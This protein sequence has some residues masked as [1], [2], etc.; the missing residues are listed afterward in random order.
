MKL[1]LR[2]AD[3]ANRYGMFER[4]RHV[5]VA[6]SGGADS[7]CLLRALVD[8]APQWDLRLSVLH[9]NHKLRGQESEEDELFVVELARQLGLPVTVRSANIAALPDNLEQAGRNAR[10]EFFRD[11]LQT[12]DMEHV[13]VGHTRDDQA[14]TVLFR[15]L[16]GSGGAGLAG[17]RPVTAE[18][19]VRPL[20]E[21]SRVEIEHFLRDRGVA[22]REDSSNSSMRFARNRIRRDLLPQLVRDWNPAVVDTLNRTAEWAHGEEEYWAK[23]IGQLAGRLISECDHGIFL[24]RAADLR[25]QPPAVGRR[26]VRHILER[27]KGDLLGVNFAH[28]K[29]VLAL[30]SGKTG[31]GSVQVPGAEVV[32]SFDWLRFAAQLNVGQ[33]EY[34]VQVKVPGVVRVKDAGVAV[35]L[36]LVETTETFRSSD[37]VYNGETGFVDWGALSGLLELRSWRPG[38][39]Y[40]PQGSAG[41]E[42]IKLLFQ[43]ARIPR[44]ERCR[45]PVLTDGDA[46]VWS[47]RFGPANRF[48]AGPECAKRLR[49]RELGP[50]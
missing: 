11:Q 47:R 8:L 4:G 27:A 43:K 28:I 1:L 31:H 45:W 12:T 21:V 38:D 33:A 17:I 30:A 32:R 20:L 41:E 9:L 46:I 42:K 15:F 13:A 44:W 7:V 39:R 35:C 3:T 18:G 36:E 50:V 24:V 14:E 5:G 34:C 16:R 37:Y 48:A 29:A 23:E 49:I 25:E 19:I 26:L 10:L 6:V 40:Q 22:W 2:I